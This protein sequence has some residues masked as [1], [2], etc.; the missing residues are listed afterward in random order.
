MHFESAVSRDLGCLVNATPNLLINYNKLYTGKDSISS[1][2]KKAKIQE[3]AYL[4]VWRFFSE[5]DER[6]VSELLF[7]RTIRSLFDGFRPT[8]TGTGCV[9]FF[10][11]C[12]A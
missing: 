3:V 4:A 9:L 12:N 8:G 7:S 11:F 10:I 6:Y 2:Q 5:N 1:T